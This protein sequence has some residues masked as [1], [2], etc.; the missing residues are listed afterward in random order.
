MSRKKRNRLHLGPLQR[1]EVHLW[2]MGLSES[3]ATV[4]V[5][6]SVQA[7][8]NIIPPIAGQI[9]YSRNAAAALKWAAGLAIRAPLVPLEETVTDAT[10]ETPAKDSSG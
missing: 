3:L 2:L 6:L 10:A 7:H 5:K 4:A 9:A 1:E 8:G